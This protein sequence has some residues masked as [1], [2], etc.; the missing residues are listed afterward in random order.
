MYRFLL[1]ALIV[2]A[3]LWA[4]ADVNVKAQQYGRLIVAVQSL[5]ATL[6]AESD[7]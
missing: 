5:S 3:A 2:L 1:F 6:A 7:P 4:V